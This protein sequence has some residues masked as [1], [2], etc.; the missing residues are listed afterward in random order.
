MKR[1]VRVLV[2][3]D[4]PLQGWLTLKMLE[5]QGM[6]TA[7]ASDGVEG[8]GSAAWSC[9]GDTAGRAVRLRFW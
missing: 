6:E 5:E 9:C 3:E 1:L 7:L 2:V 4:E 8:L